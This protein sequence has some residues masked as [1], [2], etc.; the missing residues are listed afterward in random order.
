MQFGLVKSIMLLLFL[1]GLMIGF[2][3]A[4]PVGPIGVLCIN[5]TL[6]AGLAAGLISGLGAAL[7]DAFYG[8]VAGFG[9]VSVSS[10]LQRYETF[11]RLFGGFFLAYLGVKIFL[12]HN[13]NKSMDDKASTLWQ[14]LCSTFV[15][16]L[17]NPA[18]ILAFLAI[19][20]GF[21]IVEAGA[22]YREAGCIVFGVFLGSLLW[23]LV[24]CSSVQVI[25]HKLSAGAMTWLNRLSGT[26]LI[27][28]AL[29]T[30][31]SAI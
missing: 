27:L 9:F 11:I 4:A 29:W 15:L 23:W 31:L 8:C 18:T 22:N 26:I 5:R 12:S 10:F 24:L 16:T 25:Q 6:K 30:L 20:S 3:I 21:G 13:E 17:S 14:D 7:A 19:Y 28:I 1:K 2:S